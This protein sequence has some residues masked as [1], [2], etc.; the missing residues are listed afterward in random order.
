MQFP[1]AYL[2]H[3]QLLPIPLDTYIPETKIQLLVQIDFKQISGAII[4]CISRLECT[5]ALHFERLGPSCWIYQGW[6]QDKHEY[7][8]SFYREAPAGASRVGLQ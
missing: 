3:S 4:N 2:P 1:C 7:S 8:T 5:Q 6:E